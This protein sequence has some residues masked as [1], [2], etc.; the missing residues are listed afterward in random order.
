MLTTAGTWHQGVQ[1]TGATQVFHVGGRPPITCAFAAASQALCEQK[2]ESGHWNW[3]VGVQ[4]S[5][6]TASLS[7][8]RPGLVLAQRHLPERVP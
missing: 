8:L 6:N 1:D 2:L 7:T 4:G 3:D 5:D